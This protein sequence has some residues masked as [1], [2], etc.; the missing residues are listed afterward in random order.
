MIMLALQTFLLM[1]VAYIL[2]CILGCLFHQWFGSAPKAVAVAAAVTV[3]VTV[4][5]TGVDGVG[6]PEFYYGRQ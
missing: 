1:A 3:T 2:G 5:G 6:F 4:T